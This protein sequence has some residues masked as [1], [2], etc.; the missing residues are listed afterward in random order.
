MDATVSQRI[1][2]TAACQEDEP[3]FASS[4]HLGISALQLFVL[5]EVLTG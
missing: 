5:A 1:A 2:L 4:Q 3:F